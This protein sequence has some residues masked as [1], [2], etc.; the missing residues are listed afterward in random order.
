MIIVQLSDTHFGT[1][2]PEVVE[3]LVAWMQAHQP[4]LV[5]FSGD[6]TQRARRA[7]FQ[8]ARSFID[9]IPKHDLLTVPGNHDLPMFDLLRRWLSPYGYYR[10]FFGDDLEP[11]FENDQV[12]VLC[13]NSTRP[14]R[15]KDGEISREQRDRVAQRLRGTAQHKLKILVAHHPFDVILTSDEENLI[16]QGADAIQHW[17]QAGLDLVLGGHIH[18][19]FAASLRGRYPELARDVWCVQ[20]GTTISRR[21]RHSKPNSFNRFD[22]GSGHAAAMVERWD[23]DEED[24]QFQRVAC[25][26]PWGDGLKGGGMECEDMES[27]GMERGG[28]K[29]KDTKVG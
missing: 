29:G 5:I 25:F 22:I 28:I 17:A 16:H 14:G 24:G 10:E 18:F 1:E 12:L 11:A 8:A 21:V 3:A 13:L 6:I 19:P 15:R 20:A 4:D 27:D 26:R 7:Q 2:K 23:Y 9:R